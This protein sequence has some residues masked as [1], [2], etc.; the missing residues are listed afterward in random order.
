MIHV[1]TDISETVSNFMS[2]ANKDNRYR[3]F[4][5]CY[6]YFRNTQDLTQD[7][8]KSC[9]TLGFYLASWG[10][11][12]GSSFMLQ[13]SLSH[14][15]ETIV[16]LNE[17]KISQPWV[18]EIDIDKY[19]DDNIDKLI[20]IYKK[21]CDILI[22][23]DDENKKHR[24][25]TLVTKLM[26]GVFGSVPAFDNYFIKTFTK[27]DESK[28]KF[29]VFNKNA[30]L[31]IKEFYNGNLEEI[32]NLSNSIKTLDFQTGNE[33]SISYTKAKIVDMYGFSLSKKL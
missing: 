16:Y 27:L 25:I 18:W 14:Y 22:K 28:C 10:M 21:I 6:N 1:K 9:L 26:L 17:L 33:T 29:K 19:N 23:S 30:L 31:Q 4:D 20:K 12:R 3:S 24:S 5:Y 11:Y 8:E 7:I 32:D 13:K 15:K 2:N